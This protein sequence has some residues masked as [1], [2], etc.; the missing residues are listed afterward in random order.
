MDPDDADVIVIGAGMAGLSAAAQLGRKGRRV[1][2]LE[3][4]ERVGGRVWSHRPREAGGVA[5]E[6]GAEFVHGGNAAIGALLRAA[7]LRTQ[8]VEVPM[9]WRR[10]ARLVEV[11]DFWDGVARITDAV[12]KAFKGSFGDYLAGPEAGR[13]P[14]EERER[15][16]RFAGSFNAAPLDRLSA[17]AMR[18]QRGGADDTDHRVLGPYDVI[19]ER[20][21]ARLPR[22]R[23][24]L[25]L[26]HSV[27]EVRHRPGRVEV[28][29]TDPAGGRHRTHRARAALVTLPLGVLQ[30]RAV[31]FRPALGRKQELIDALGWGT[32]VRMTLRF[33]D[34]LWDLPLLPPELRAGRGAR[35]GYVNAPG[36]PLPTWWAL[37][38][39][40]PLLTGWAGG[41]VAE[42][43][44][45]LT[46]DGLREAALAS[47]AGL[48]GARV[49][50]WRR[51]LVEV[52]AHDWRA[53]PY[54][55][56][57]YSYPTAGF[58]RGPAR[59]AR[60]VAGTLFFAGEATSGALGTVH[61]ALES[62]LRAANEILEVV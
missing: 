8:P 21:R 9:R 44:G 23:V 40:A 59:L 6:L 14:D 41:E 62:G 25:A 12:P 1:L 27:C 37:A 51:R 15:V 2:L 7:R 31:D 56:G 5:V 3:A 53:D 38:A 46:P 35:F 33:H 36:L 55:R 57:A 48:G 24:R 42:R 13:F 30:A 61:G 47:L 32:V 50:A 43:L 22:S 45:A 34:A 16:G 52:H 26:G 17:Q 60:P 20:L 39:P 58:E 10:D 11:P 18:A 4:R 54:S 19:V 28:T 29:S 49:E